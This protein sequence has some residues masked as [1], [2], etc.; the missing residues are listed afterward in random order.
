MGLFELCLHADAGKPAADG[1]AQGPD[2]KLVRISPS[3][4][5]VVSTCVWR[6]TSTVCIRDGQEKIRAA[7]IRVDERISQEANDT[8]QPLCSKC[9]AALPH[10]QQVWRSILQFI[11]Q[12][13]SVHNLVYLVSIV[14]HLL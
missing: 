9:A 4:G 6:Q 5:C 12:G 11:Y 3:S 8:K 2:M 7:V 13:S 14:Y 1:A 10:S